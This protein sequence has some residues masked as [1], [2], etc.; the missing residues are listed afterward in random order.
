MRLLIDS[1]IVVMVL[2]I[3]IGV[4]QYR[5]QSTRL[6]RDVQ[7]VRRGLE[8]FDSILEFQGALWQAQEDGSSLYPPQV[9]PGWFKGAPPRN[10]LVTGDRPWLDIAPLED[11]HDQPP[12]ALAT[13]PGQA[14][15]WYNPTL[16]VVRARVPRQDTDR[17]TLELYNRVNG[18]ALDALPIDHDPEREPLA[19]NLNP[20]TAGQHASPD[21]RTV[22]EVRS[23]DLLLDQ[24]QQQADRQAGVEQ[25][26]VPWWDKSKAQEG[27]QSGDRAQPQDA[28][29]PVPVRKTLR[30]R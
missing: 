3:I 2:V 9:M 16:G 1:M 18:T 28:G 19:M 21:T 4:V 7:A 29:A 26:A 11:Y 24:A 15:F 20:V 22:D 12:D 8:E 13:G 14:A 10:P 5:H 17:L 23:Y 30:S 25:Q 27:K 6:E